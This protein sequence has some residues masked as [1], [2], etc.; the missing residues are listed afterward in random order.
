M[1]RSTSIV[2][3]TSQTNPENRLFDHRETAQLARVPIRSLLKYWRYGIIKPK[4][5]GERYGIYFEEEAIYRVRKAENIRATMA[6]N[7]ASAA[8]I[9]KLVEENERLTTELNFI[10]KL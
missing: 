9:F 7:I 1:T 5:R 10:R 4:N 2:R 6:T 3:L 8:A